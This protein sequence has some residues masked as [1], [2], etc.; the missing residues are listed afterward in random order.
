MP[1]A[2]GFLN[3]HKPLNLTSH[4]VV[5]R[6]RR[7]LGIKRVG[8][9][10]TLDPLAEGV[11]IICVG[12]ATRLSEYVMSSTKTYRAKILLGEETTTYDAEGEVVGQTPTEHITRAD[13]EDVLPTIYWK[14]KTVA[15][16]V[17]CGQTGRT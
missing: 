17:Q 6:V 15:A 8:H 11:L 1:E 14:H 10:G 7:K 13:V 4:D 3:I 2:F 5:N 9:A 16:D 12:R